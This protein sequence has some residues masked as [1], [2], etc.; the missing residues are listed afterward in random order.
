MREL[1]SELKSIASREGCIYIVAIADT[2]EGEKFFLE[3]G[4]EHETD[5]VNGRECLKLEL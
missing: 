4:F 2:E 1:F 5:R 3:N